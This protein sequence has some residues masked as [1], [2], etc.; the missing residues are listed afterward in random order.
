MVHQ[1]TVVDSL[2]VDAKVALK[3]AEEYPVAIITNR[4]DD[5]KD[6]I[7]TISDKGGSAELFVADTSSSENIADTI[8]SI[9]QR[10]GKICT[11]AIYQFDYSRKP[12]PFL[13]QSV[14]SL[15]QE[16][17][18]PIEGAY[19]FAQ[20]TLPLLSSGST[21]PPTLLFSSPSGDSYYEI[22][23]DNALMA[24]SRSLGREFGP[25]G[26]HVSHVKVKR[27]GDADEGSTAASH[28][29]ITGHCP[30]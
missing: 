16:S 23:N 15:R 7:K 1:L 3:F 8:S 9:T 12:K 22:V 13:K 26:V 10:F 17:V 18:L 4:K 30:G 21:H 2:D 19:S 20:H 29:S 25:K 5:L 14:A 28:V 27:I 24:L 6:T 11:V